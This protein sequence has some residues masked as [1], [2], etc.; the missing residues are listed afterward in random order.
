[1]DCQIVF[2]DLKRAFTTVSILG[3]WDP[4]L[5]IILEMDASDCALAA[6]LSTQ[7]DS[8]I[9]PIAFMSRAFSIAELNYDVHDQELLAIVK[10]FKKW[11]H[12]F[13]GV[14]DPVKIYTNHR[15]LIYFS[16]TK[17]LS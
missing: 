10:S 16:K 1:M 14:A 4:G 9:C 7:I 2:D 13:E 12:Y 17:M 3:H 8:K 6:I 11:R 5:P 15:N